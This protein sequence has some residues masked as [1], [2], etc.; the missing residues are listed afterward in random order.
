[1]S[2]MR[3]YNN[4]PGQGEILLDIVASAFFL[5][6]ITQPNARLRL[7][8]LTNLDCACHRHFSLFEH[9]TVATLGFDV[10][11]TRTVTAHQTGARR[12]GGLRVVSIARVDPKEIAFSD[13][14][15]N[16]YQIPAILLAPGLKITFANSRY[17]SYCEQGP[18]Q[19]QKRASSASSYTSASFH[20]HTRTFPFR[21]TVKITRSF[22]NMLSSSKMLL[23]CLMLLPYIKAEQA[24]K[25]K[26][27]DLCEGAEPN[28]GKNATISDVGLFMTGFHATWNSRPVSIGAPC[29]RRQTID[30]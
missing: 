24:E 21:R 7:M 11:Q 12:K 23:S 2:M 6:Q 26:E 14:G 13:S 8:S 17:L 1:M 30:S 25:V 5:C 22:A 29:V 3:R 15:C 10:W 16:V 27:Y 18:N 28:V 20:I 9:G 4:D 19:T